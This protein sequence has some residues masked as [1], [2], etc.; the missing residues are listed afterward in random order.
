MLATL[1]ALIAGTVAMIAYCSPAASFL[2]RPEPPDTR[3]LWYEQILNHLLR[4][5]ANKMEGA[6][7]ALAIL[8]VMKWLEEVRGAGG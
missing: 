7:I 8:L 2:N 1:S 3:S 4:T 6:F 5:P